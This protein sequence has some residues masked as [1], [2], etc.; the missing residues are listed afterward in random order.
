MPLQVDYY[1]R[2]SFE[3]WILTV[4]LKDDKWNDVFGIRGLNVS[5]TCYLFT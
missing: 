4:R 2:K 5:L 3:S 1:L